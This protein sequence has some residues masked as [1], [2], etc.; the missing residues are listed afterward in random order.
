MKINYTVIKELE[1]KRW[2]NSVIFESN[3]QSTLENDPPEL[4]NKLTNA[5]R[6]Q[7]L[8]VHQSALVLKVN[9]KLNFFGSGILVKQLHENSN[10]RWTHTLY[11]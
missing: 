10:I 2:K 4:L 3:Y 11:L 7:G 8:N 1:P 5:V 6:R 9:G